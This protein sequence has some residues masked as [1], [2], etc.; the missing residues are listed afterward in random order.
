MQLYLDSEQELEPVRVE[1]S[2]KVVWSQSNEI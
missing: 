2:A 1:I